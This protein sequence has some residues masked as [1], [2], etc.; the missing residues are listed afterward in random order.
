MAFHREG[1]IDG[2]DRTVVGF[3]VRESGG[4]FAK[5]LAQVRKTLLGV[6]AAGD[7]RC[8]RKRCRGEGIAHI[9]TGQLN[10]LAVA[11]VAIDHGH[12]NDATRYSQ[13]CTNMQVL[14]CLGHDAIYRR[15]HQ[16]DHVDAAG[17]RNHGSD[18]SIMSGNID[19]AD[20]EPAS[21]IE[22]RKPEFDGE[23]AA[24]FL[25]EAV[26]VDTGE[27]PDQG[28]F[29]V[30]DVPGGTQY[31]RTGSFGHGRRHLTTVTLPPMTDAIHQANQ[32]RLTQ[33]VK[34]GG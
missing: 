5:G 7:D 9:F 29:A 19:D 31:K 13:Q 23:A 33:L 4:K 8:I 26:G 21:E 32:V 16:Q 15:N 17:P 30:V 18:K 3:A 6:G 25:A 27:G 22:W 2:K 20:L 12:G 10:R 14:P 34:G 11:L 24:L 1:A 28:C